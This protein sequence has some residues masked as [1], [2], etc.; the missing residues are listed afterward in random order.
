MRPVASIAVLE[1]L[2]GK[3]ADLGCNVD[4][5]YS[6]LIEELA[7]DLDELAAVID[8]NPRLA[9]ELRSQAA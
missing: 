9:S 6:G 2:V 7:V 1:V 8:K 5:I 4:Q 3:L